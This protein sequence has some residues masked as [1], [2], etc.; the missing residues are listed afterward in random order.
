MALIRTVAS[1]QALSAA[2]QAL[3]ASEQQQQQQHEPPPA[4]LHPSVVKACALLEA[5]QVSGDMAALRRSSFALM[6][7]A[8]LAAAD[9]TKAYR[10]QK[11]KLLQEQKAARAAQT[12]WVVERVNLQEEVTSLRTRLIAARLDAQES[13]SALAAAEAKSVEL[14]Q[15]LARQEQDVQEAGGAAAAAREGAEASRREAA[16]QA[17]MARAQADQRI[18]MGEQ[19]VRVSEQLSETRTRLRATEAQL[20]AARAE[21]LAERRVAEERANALQRLH[22]GI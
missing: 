17:S 13:R 21:V 15:Q 9:H 20:A 22:A 12:G 7:A 4:T 6:R 5:A 14:S 2:W 3:A 10:K 1:P 11:A 18:Y 19:C 8:E 16:A